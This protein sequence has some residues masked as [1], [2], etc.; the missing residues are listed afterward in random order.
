LFAV[1][2]G[3]MAVTRKV[4]WYKGSAELLGGRAAFAPPPPPSGLGL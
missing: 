4:D 3:V 2:A 1:L